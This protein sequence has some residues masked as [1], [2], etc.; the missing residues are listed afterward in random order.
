MEMNRRQIVCPYCFKEFIDDEVCFRSERVELGENPNIPEEYE[1]FTDFMKRSRD[2]E[3]V[4]RRIIEGTKEWEFFSAK[5]DDQYESF[6]RM[7]NGT[8]ERG[9]RID[10]T[11]GVK[12]YER[13]VINPLNEYHRDYLRQQPDGG[14]LI[15]DSEGMVKQVQLQSGEVCSRRVCPY[16]HNPLPDGFGKS[17]A[18]SIVVIGITGSGKTVFL[19]QLLKG[20]KKYAGKVGISASPLGEN[21]RQFYE[22]FNVQ[23][24]YPLPASTPTRQ[25]QQ[26]LFFDLVQGGSSGEKMTDTLVLYDVA[27]EV[28]TDSGMVRSYAPFVSHADGFVLLID[29]D[30]FDVVS[31]SNASAR[32]LD[33]PTKVLDTIH[34]IVAESANKKCHIPCAVCISKA[35][36]MS[37]QSALGPHLSELLKE[38]VVALRG[39]NR[40]PVTQFNAG[41]HNE[42]ARELD[43][44]LRHHS[45]ML[46]QQM[47]SSY[48]RFSFFAF[49]ALGCEVAD[50]VINDVPCKYPVGPVI[51]RRVEEP[52]F[53][54][55]NAFGFIGSD[56]STY[57]P[58]AGLG[59]C[60]HCG[61]EQVREL[62][63]GSIY[64][65]EKSSKKGLFGLKKE[66]EEFSV[67]RV[68]AKC[69][70]QWWDD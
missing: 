57:D 68:C 67:N 63:D 34:S 41:D 45:P 60:P 43:D 29:P 9:S 48:E 58:A 14:Y 53:W 27:G 16:C 38:D 37:M 46:I 49:S 11:F 33:D 5:Q 42:I 25:L 23:A 6:W 12:A 52:L 64:R 19:S 65:K 21:A 26:P 69:G 59:A 47:L 10:E 54:L 7:Y 62:P 3:D 40:L 32:V 17:P 1:D 44:W 22:T 39:P 36:E 2:P 15:S 35:D 24:N 30:Q 4:R 13:P 61:S 31:G 55:F 18:K 8:S 50:G 70:E 20:M 66:I 56:R 28:L 51:P